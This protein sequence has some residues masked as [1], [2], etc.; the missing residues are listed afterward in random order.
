MERQEYLR[1][2]DEC[3]DRVARWGDGFDPDELEVTA[4]DGVVTLEFAD[5]TR[6]VLNRQTAANQMWFAAQARA[7]HYDWNPGRKAWLDDKDGHELF[8]RIEQCV[9]ERGVAARPLA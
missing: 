4:T 5:R 2:A 3:L 6:F 1:L 7:W 9:A 8:G